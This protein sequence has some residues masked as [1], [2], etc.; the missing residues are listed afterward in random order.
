MGEVDPISSDT[1]IL[2]FFTV[3]VYDDH[4][5]DSIKQAILL[6]SLLSPTCVVHSDL[7]APCPLRGYHAK[8]GA[9]KWLFEMAKKIRD[10]NHV[11]A[12]AN[13][14]PAYIGF[15]RER[16][17]QLISGDAAAKHEMDIA[18]WSDVRINS[19]CPSLFYLQTVAL[20]YSGHN[21]MVESGINGFNVAENA[22]RNRAGEKYFE[23]VTKCVLLPRDAFRAL[24]KSAGRV[25]QK[26]GKVRK[27]FNWTPGESVEIEMPSTQELEQCCKAVMAEE[28][29]ERKRER[30]RQRKAL[31]NQEAVGGQGAVPLRA[32]G[33]P[34]SE[35]MD[36]AGLADGE[37]EDGMQVEGDGM[38]E[39][40]PEGNS[41][42]PCEIMSHVLLEGDDDGVLGFQVKWEDGD[43]T[44]ETARTVV[45]WGKRHM[46]DDYLDSM[47][48]DEVRDELE[49]CL[50][51]LEEEL[52]GS[53]D[54]E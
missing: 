49:L 28:D 54:D 14:W 43:K 18:F 26:G 5:K 38:P 12:Y 24:R 53:D 13:E 1:I 31:A 23:E 22:L 17:D 36:E 35:G 2:P 21:A 19:K 9:V 44:Y 45:G 30:N 3:Q 41:A 37:D 47:H 29:A 15:I 20:A 51:E 27:R 32:R 10:G 33:A 34:E 48:D 4:F 16:K 50:A 7:S 46:V 52:D 39:T 25:G 8:F 6:Q 11:P 40:A 42:L